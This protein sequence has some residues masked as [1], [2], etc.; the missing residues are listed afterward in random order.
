MRLC[1]RFLEITSEHVPNF[2]DL[3]KKPAD[4][5]NA[6]FCSRFPPHCHRP[7]F[8]GIPKHLQF[9]GPELGGT[10]VRIGVVAGLLAWSESFTAGN[11]GHGWF[12]SGHHCVGSCRMAARE[13]SLKKSLSS[14]VSACGDICR[15]HN[16]ARARALDGE[17]A[18]NCKTNGTRGRLKL[19]S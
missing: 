5:F 6:H 4:A 15:S 12:F 17:H 7:Q 16:K 8:N 19:R 9:G 3:A 13:K 2:W 18:P 1:P 11:V 14:A 10:G